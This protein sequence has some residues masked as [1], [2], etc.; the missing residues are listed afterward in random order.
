[1][2]PFCSKGLLAPST[3]SS[4]TDPSYIFQ[5]CEGHL[6]TQVTWILE[7]VLW[8]E[9]TCPMP[10]HLQ[11]AW[12]A[13]ALPST[14]PSVFYCS[15]LAQLFGPGKHFTKN[16]GVWVRQVQNYLPTCKPEWGATA[17]IFCHTHPWGVCCSLR[18]RA[19]KFCCWQMTKYRLENWQVTLATYRSSWGVSLILHFKGTLQTFCENDFGK[20]CHDQVLLATGEALGIRV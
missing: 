8:K 17:G 9:A 16:R 18:T 1:M 14:L 2:F 5:K 7:P 15:L 13:V 10:S 12:S 20:V 3:L 19:F 11:D 4:G 6:P